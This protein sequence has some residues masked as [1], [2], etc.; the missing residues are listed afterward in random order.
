MTSHRRLI[1]LVA[2]GFVLAV[3]GGYAGTQIAHSINSSAQ[4][5]VNLARANHEALHQG[6]LIDCMEQ[7]K[8][9]VNTVKALTRE[10]KTPS[11]R[12]LDRMLYQFFADRHAPGLAKRFAA[13]QS[14][15]R[16]STILLID[17]LSPLQNCEHVAQRLAPTPK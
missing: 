13:S 12:L 15:S 5:A 3:G 9:H 6:V 7:N 17:A 11:G 14:A 4:T 1:T 2:L 10:E 8:R 16:G